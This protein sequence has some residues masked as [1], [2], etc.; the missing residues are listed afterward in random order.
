MNTACLVAHVSVVLCTPVMSRPD[1]HIICS[2][3]LCFLLGERHSLWEHRCVNRKD[4]ATPLSP[5]VLD[6]Q[7]CSIC[8]SRVVSE[9]EDQSGSDSLFWR[10]ANFVWRTSWNYAV[11]FVILAS[12][13]DY[14]R[15]CRWDRTHLC[16]LRFLFLQL[17][18]FLYRSCV[19][20]SVRMLVGSFVGFGSGL[21]RGIGSPSRHLGVVG[22][23]F[24][25]V[26]APLL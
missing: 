24:P 9:I 26:K 5:D 4:V 17:H 2:R 13:D 19:C 1:V 25:S 20:S 7:V 18:H 3:C 23:Q 12:P 6:L 15:Y 11:S 14:P 8:C 16:M 21:S 22:C 10:L